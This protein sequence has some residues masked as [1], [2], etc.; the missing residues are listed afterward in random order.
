MVAFQDPAVA[1]QFE[2]MPEDVRA[3]LL[4]VRALIF[5]V[6]AEVSEV[7]ALTE[8]LKWGQPA[9]VTAETKSGSTLRL[10]VPKAGG[11][12]V[13]AHCQTSI[14]SDF[15]EIFPTGFR[16]DGNRG[17]LFEPGEEVPLEALRLLVHGALT[18]HVARRRASG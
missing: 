5:E 6:A 9:Y 12:G 8:T 11:F 2:A 18:Y 14:I 7:G 4:Q 3:P 15:R 1:A 17:V 10:G 16:F 13:F